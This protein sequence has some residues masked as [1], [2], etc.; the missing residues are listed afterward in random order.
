MTERTIKNIIRE[1]HRK[2]AKELRIPLEEPFRRT[3]I[4]VLNL[5]YAS[6]SKGKNL[7]I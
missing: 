4:N 1:K 6:D 3:V 2:Q 7:I 5:V